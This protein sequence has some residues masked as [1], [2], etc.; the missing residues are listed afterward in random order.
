MIRMNTQ[1]LRDLAS[2]CAVN[3][4][5]SISSITSR[6]LCHRGLWWLALFHVVAGAVL[7]KAPCILIIHA[8]S[9]R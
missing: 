3:L 2:L 1:R 9:L 8:I 5:I 7:V 4:A 6:V